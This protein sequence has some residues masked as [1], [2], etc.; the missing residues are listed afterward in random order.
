MTLLSKA[1]NEMQWHQRFIELARHKAGWSKDPST[2]VGAIIVDHLRRDIAHGYN[3]FA[4]GIADTAERLADREMRLLLT[5]HAEQNAIL[6]ARR[7]VT[8]CTIYCT[9][10]PCM[11]CT[12]MIIQSGISRVVTAPWT[13]PFYERWGKDIELS[14]SL[15][16]EAGLGYLVLESPT[17]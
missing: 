16:A 9:H 8:G 5:V 6:N 10:A 12:K 1:N 7:D 17:K 4:R 3:G 11:Q 2:R 14:R 15:F 13:A